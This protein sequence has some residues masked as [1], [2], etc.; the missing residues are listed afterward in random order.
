MAKYIKSHS[1]FVLSQKHQDIKDGTVLDRDIT[2]IGGISDFPSSQVPIYRSGNF[3]ISVRGGS[4][5]TNEYNSENWSEK[6]NDT[7]IEYSFPKFFII[8]FS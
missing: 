1:N 5:P 7:F 6:G 3:L 4:K 8:K 2:T